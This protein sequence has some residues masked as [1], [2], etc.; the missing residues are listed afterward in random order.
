MKNLKETAFVRVFLVVFVFVVF[1]GVVGVD[2]ASARVEMEIELEG[3]PTDGTDFGGGGGGSNDG[4]YI[5]KYGAVEVTD[6][7]HVRVGEMFLVIVPGF[8][9][10][11]IVF[12]F[13]V[14]LVLD[15]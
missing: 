12:C 4:E 15:R 1:V 14:E 7:S 10:G 6:E 2:E 5:S 3:D 8:V 11:G 13:E 9:D